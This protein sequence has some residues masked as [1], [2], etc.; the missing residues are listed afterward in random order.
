MGVEVEMYITGQSA[1]AKA[2]AAADKEATELFHETTVK[3]G[4]SV[5]K[6]AKSRIK[7]HPSGLWAEKGGQSKNY[8]TKTTQKLAVSVTA[9]SKAQAITEFANQGH[10][11]QGVHLV[12]YLTREYGRD[13]GR[14]L[15]RAWDDGDYESEVETA[16][17][18]LE[19]KIKASTE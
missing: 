5:A 14:V 2:L 15:W 18:A 4:R 6:D 3:I 9:S 11:P 8:K 17:A 10:I 13:S 12:D 7:P 16:V 1:V 19:K